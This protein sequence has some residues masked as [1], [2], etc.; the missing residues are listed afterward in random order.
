[1]PNEWLANCHDAFIFSFST[2]QAV[3]LPFCALLSPN[4]GNS[5]WLS[6]AP[7]HSLH[8]RATACVWRLGRVTGRSCS[9][10]CPEALAFLIVV[11]EPIAPFVNIA[12]FLGKQCHAILSEEER[13]QDLTLANAL[14]SIVS[15]DSLLVFKGLS[16]TECISSEQWMCRFFIK[17]PKVA[18]RDRKVSPAYFHLWNTTDPNSV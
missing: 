5:I 16:W 3:N 8:I 14:S 7:P 18:L 15:T 9:S 2:E 11:L 10:T 17:C 12:F 6:P 13:Q 1:M 4:A